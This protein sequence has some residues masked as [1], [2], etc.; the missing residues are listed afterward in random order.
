[1]LNSFAMFEAIFKFSLIAISIDP[2]V[3][4]VA[5]SSTLAPL[6]YVGIS[7]SASPDSRSVLEAI[8]PLTFIHLSVLPFIS[9]TALRFPSY[10]ISLID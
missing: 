3:Y 5:I 8:D 2:S 6:P 4:T 1:M 9:S 10:I 7:F